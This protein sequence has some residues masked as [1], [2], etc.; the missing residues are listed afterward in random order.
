MFLLRWL[1]WNLFGP[2]FGTR[3]LAPKYPFQRNVWDA[4]LF[5]F[6]DDEAGDVGG[7]IFPMRP[8][9][10]SC[11]SYSPTQRGSKLPVAQRDRIPGTEDVEQH[12]QP[13]RYGDAFRA[14]FGL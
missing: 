1:L 11:F 13:T 8:F 6:R 5:R 7:E 14:R 3:T 9:L 4:K 12:R 2:L 10:Y